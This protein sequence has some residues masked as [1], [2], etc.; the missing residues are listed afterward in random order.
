[1]QSAA[2]EETSSQRGHRDVP[3]AAAATK[4]HGR[5]VTCVHQA[6]SPPGTQRVRYLSMDRFFRVVTPAR[7]RGLLVVP[8]AV[9]VAV[10]ARII[11][12][13]SVLLVPP[14]MCCTGGP[15]RAEAPFVLTEAS[16]SLVMERCRSI[17][18]FRPVVRADE[19]LP[20]FCSV[21]AS[22]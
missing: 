12:S 21:P 7:G 11:G 17:C 15:A 10:D 18:L 14:I 16:P 9:R 4:P 5:D 13:D 6:P 22:S 1:V 8:V 3:D 20:V 19:L 2:V